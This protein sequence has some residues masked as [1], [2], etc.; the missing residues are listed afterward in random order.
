MRRVFTGKLSSSWSDLLQLLFRDLGPLGHSVAPMSE[1]CFEIRIADIG[2][3]PLDKNGR[4]SFYDAA[5]EITYRAFL[6][7]R[8]D[9]IQ[10]FEAEHADIFA[11]MKLFQPSAILPTLEIVDFTSWRHKAIIEYLCLYQTVT[12]RKQVGRRMGLLVWDAGQTAHRPLIGAAI[13]ASPRWSQ[14]LRDHHLG[15]ASDFPKTSNQYNARERAIRMVGLSRMMQLSVACA[16]P[17][18]SLLSGAWLM[19][20]APF[21]MNGQEAFVRA[22]RDESDPDLAI[23]VTT[24]AKGASGAPFRNHRIK[25]LTRGHIDT[26]GDVFVR[27]A[28]DADHPALRASFKDLISPETVQVACDLFQVEFPYASKNAMEAKAIQLMLRRF[29][30]KSDI[31][32]GNE[33]GVHVGMLNP[34]TKDYLSAGKPRPPNKR[35][36]LNWDDII[37]VWVRKFLPQAE[38]DKSEDHKVSRR[39]RAEAARAYPE[40]QIPLSYRLSHLHDLARLSVSDLAHEPGLSDT[41]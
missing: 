12:S 3:F 39:R 38:S 41:Y 40:D 29:K 11:R 1:G 25:Q 8:A 9:F 22:V 35:P 32:D 28:P 31:F 13:L 27:V 16:L 19:A 33:I 30:I 21:T 7:T 10:T 34:E 36:R 24:T 14:A 5:H 23:V 4:V 18:Y 6:P 37:A 15:W 2:D 17:P 20:L 26:A